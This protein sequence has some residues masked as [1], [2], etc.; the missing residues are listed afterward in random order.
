MVG[1]REKAAVM[2]PTSSF[3]AASVTCGGSAAAPDP[4]LFL[5]LYSEGSSVHCSCR[6]NE[7][8]LPAFL[9]CHTNVVDIL[10][11]PMLLAEVLGEHEL[12]SIYL[13]SRAEE[14]LLAPQPL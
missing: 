1:S 9:S 3:P 7:G 4:G 14:R 10:A 13:V 2:L 12:G 8:Q 6:G 11:N 5:P